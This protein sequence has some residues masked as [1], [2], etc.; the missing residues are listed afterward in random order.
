MVTESTPVAGEGAPPLSGVRVVDFGHYIAGPLA[1]MLL[2]DQGAEVIKV[3]RPGTRAAARSDPVAAM[4]NRGKTRLELDLK[5]PAGVAAAKRLIAAADVVIENFRPGVMERARARG[6]GADR[7]AAAVDLPVAAGVRLH[8]SREGPRARVRGGAGSR[9]RAVYGPRFARPPG[10]CS[11]GVHADS[12]GLDLRGHSRRAGGDAR[13]L[14]AR[15]DRRRR[16]DR[17]AAVGRSA[18]GDRHSALPGSAAAGALRHADHAALHGA[19]PGAAGPRLRA[20]DR[21]RRLAAGSCACSAASRPAPTTA[22]AP[23]T[24]AGCSCSPAAT[25]TTASGFSRRWVSTTS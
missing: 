13:P 20:P 14:R 7:A 1:G 21:R 12:A 18:G 15:A 9:L 4:Y 2:A 25:P 24:A 23:A 19:G 5:T 16:R 22:T 10:R 3:D 17:G 6:Q 11:A 8:R